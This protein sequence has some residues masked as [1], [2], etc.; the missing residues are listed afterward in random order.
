MHHWDFRAKKLK[1]LVLI[2]CS[3]VHVANQKL[4]SKSGMQS[5]RGIPGGKPA[6]FF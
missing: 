4:H 2:G 3:E 1:T 5:A 6:E